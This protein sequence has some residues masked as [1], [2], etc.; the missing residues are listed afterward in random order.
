M[1]MPKFTWLVRDFSLQLERQ[2]HAITAD[3]YLDQALQPLEG[4]PDEVGG[5]NAIRNAVT[6]AF[7]DRSCF[8]LVR[9]VDDEEKL[10]TL[11]SGALLGTRPPALKADLCA[12]APLVMSVSLSVCLSVWVWAVPPLAAKP[13]DFRPE[14][15][16]QVKRFVAYA[17]SRA[18]TKRLY[19]H[20]LNGA[21]TC[22]CLWGW[23]AHGRTDAHRNGGTVLADLARAYVTAINTGAVP[24][25]ASAWESVVRIEGAKALDHAKQAYDTGCVAH[26]D[27]N[28]PPKLNRCA[29]PGMYAHGRM[30]EGL[31]AKGGILDADEL[32]SLHHR[33]RLAA[34]ALYRRQAIGGYQKE[35]DEELEVTTPPP[36]AE[37]L[38]TDHDGYLCVCVCVCLSLS[39]LCVYVYV[40]V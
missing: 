9:P 3:E 37:R 7:R 22:A 6:L 19:G 30:A 13:A 31:S 15:L 32:M 23:G 28:L 34:T 17:Y 11:Q 10:Q 26:L 27:A 39:L 16:E 40:C 33:T 12:C 2:G 18:P 1:Y 4:D 24:T 21:S 8:T 38:G 20:T 36:A 35:F 14:Y 25:I 29:L 5:K